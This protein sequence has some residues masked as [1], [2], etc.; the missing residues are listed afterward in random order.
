MPSP[1]RLFFALLSIPVLFLFLLFLYSHPTISDLF[2]TTAHSSKLPE[3]IFGLLHFVTS[4][5]EAGRLVIAPANPARDGT[6]TSNVALDNE[7]QLEDVVAPEKPVGM[8]W[9]ALG[10]ITRASAHRRKGQEKSANEW[11]QRLRVLREEY[12]I[13]VFSKVR[14]TDLYVSRSTLDTDDTY[15]LV[16]IH[17]RV[18][19]SRIARK[20]SRLIRNSGFDQQC[21]TARYS[22]RAKRLL[23]IYDL[24]PAPKIIEVDLRGATVALGFTFADYRVLPADSSHIKTLLTRLTHRSTFPNV[25]LHGRSLGGS[26]DLVRLHEEDRLRQVLEE[27]G[28]EV[29]WTGEGGQDILI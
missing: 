12:P 15:L 16:R 26:D 7:T 14:Q 3:E 25:I 19:I 22:K 28:V 4:P 24:S 27:G 20:S 18:P 5:D 6:R 13:V 8:A 2:S 17:R 9:Y 1:R 29:R 23:E 10:S 21:L 11:Q